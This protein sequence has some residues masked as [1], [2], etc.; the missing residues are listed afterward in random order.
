MP[1]RKTYTIAGKEFY[2]K[3]KHPLQE[4]IELN[5]IIKK[6]PTLDNRQSDGL[7][8]D[9]T[10]WLLNTILEPVNKDTDKSILEKIDEETELIVIADFFLQRLNLMRIGTE[11][12]KSIQ[13]N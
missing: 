3:E 12:L 11:Y 7:N 4:R 2:L 13:K 5:K 10:V 8:Y 9:E 1:E 6:I